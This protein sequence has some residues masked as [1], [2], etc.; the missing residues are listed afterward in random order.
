MSVRNREK[1]QYL[2]V[3]GPL[4]ALTLLVWWMI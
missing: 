4:M 1:P 3:L 2:A